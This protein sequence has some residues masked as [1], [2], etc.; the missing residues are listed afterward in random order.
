MKITL[1]LAL[2]FLGVWLPFAFMDAMRLQASIDQ[3]H[4]APARL[5]RGGR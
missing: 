4:N 2:I 1:I 3:V 5:A